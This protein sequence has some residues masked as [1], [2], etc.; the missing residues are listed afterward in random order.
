MTPVL[1][2]ASNLSCDDSQGMGL[3]LGHTQ[4]HYNYNIQNQF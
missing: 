4:Y 3:A 2:P 1:P